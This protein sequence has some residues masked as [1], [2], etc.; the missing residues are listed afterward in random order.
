VLPFLQAKRKLEEHHGRAHERHVLAMGRIEQKHARE[1]QIALEK[2]RVEKA[3]ELRQQ[4][5]LA[6]QAS[7]ELVKVQ[8]KENGLRDQLQLLEKE[9][10][11]I[12]KM[13]VRER[14]QHDVDRQTLYAI[15]P[16]AFNMHSTEFLNLPFPFILRLTKCGNLEAAVSLRVKQDEAKKRQHKALM[17][18]ADD[19]SMELKLKMKALKK[20]EGQWR[21]KRAKQ[22]RQM[23]VELEAV[24]VMKSGTESA[25]K[26]MARQLSGMNKRDVAL[27][28][29]ADALKKERAYQN[30]FSES[31]KG[32]VLF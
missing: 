18:K 21:W 28:L 24:A 12:V 22:A 26:K 31:G 15:L 29:R 9:H 6:R 25:K 1:V 19:S 14:R 17:E 11:G 27:G 23:W 10:N 2:D 3:G 30:R 5:R 13:I 7:V 8:V 32:P 20:E 16:L 4:T